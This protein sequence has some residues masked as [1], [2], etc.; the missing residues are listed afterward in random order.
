[1]KKVSL[2]SIVI[3]KLSITIIVITLV[4]NTSLALSKI[5]YL[6]FNNDNYEMYVWEGRNVVFLTPTNDLDPEIMNLYIKAVDDAYEFYLNAT[7]KRPIMHNSYNYNG[8][9]TIAIV[10]GTC[11]AGCGFLGL[12]GIEIDKNYFDTEYKDIRDKN[13]YGQILFYELGRNFWFYGNKIEMGSSATAFAVFMRDMVYESLKLS[14]GD[15]RGRP[16]YELTN[17][18]EGLLA[19]YLADPRY[20][21]E[22]TILE[23]NAPQNSFNLGGESMLTSFLYYLEE[24]YGEF[25][26]INKLWKEAGNRQDAHDEYKAADNFIIASSIAANQNLVPLFQNWRWPVSQNAI[27]EIAVLFGEGQMITTI[28]IEDNYSKVTDVGSNG[29]VKIRSFPINSNDKGVAI[30]DT[31]DKIDVAFNIPSSG[32]YKLRVWL[33]SGNSTNPTSYFNP[34]Y[35]YQFDISGIGIV[36]FDGVPTSVQGPYTEWGGSHWGFMEATVNFS[37]GGP[38]TLG[39]TAKYVWQAVDYLEIIEENVSS[40]CEGDITLSSQAEVDAFNCTEVL[41]NLTISG[42]DITNLEGLASLTTIRGSL[43]ISNNNSLA[44]LDGLSSVN[45]V[46][47][48]SIQSN[49]ALTNIDGLTSIT[50]AYY[51][52]ISS[53]D[54]LTNIDGLH[55]VTSAT[56]IYIF[57]NNLLEDI[58]GLSSLTTLEGPLIISNNNSLHNLDGLLSLNTIGI[59]DWQYNDSE[60]LIISGNDVLTNIDGLSSLTSIEGSLDIHENT[61]LLNLDGLS[62]LTSVGDD[63]VIQS[64]PAL[65]SCCGLFP[66]LNAVGVSGSID[67]SNNGAGCTQIDI[68]EGGYCDDQTT[69]KLE[70]EDNYS[71][72]SDVGSNGTIIIR[73]FP[74]NSNGK[75][76]AIPDMGDKI[77]VTFNIPAAGQYKLK[78][79]LRSGNATMPTSYF[80]SDYSYQ[81]DISGIGDVHFVGVPSSVQGPFDAWGGSHW[82]FMEATVNF[83]SSGTKT[84]GIMAKYVWQAVDYLEIIEE[85]VCVVCEGDITLS[86]Q[87]EVDAF[88]CTEV[89]GL[90]ISGR[91]ITNL[92]GLASLIKVFS[93]FI[94]DNANLNNIDGLHSLKTVNNILIANNNSLTNL[95]GLSSVTSLMSISIV[96]NQ[97]LKN[98]DGLSSINKPYEIGIDNNDALA[99]IDGLCSVTSAGYIDISNNN[100]LENIDGLSSLSTLYDE[101]L[102]ISGND[103]LTNIDGLSLLTSIYRNMLITDNNILK[104]LDGFSS[105]TSVGEDLVVQDNPALISCCGLFPLLNAGGVSGSIDISNNGAGC[106]QN[107]ILEGGS[108]DDQTTTKIEIEDNYS[109]VSDVGSNGAIIIRSFSINSNGKAVAIPD[110]GDKINVAFDIPSAGQYKLKVWLRSG[111]ATMPTSYFNTD[112]SYQFDISGIGDVKFV[113]VPSSVQGPFDE[114]GGS[115]WG[116]MEATIDFSSGG[117]KTLGIMAKYVW[118]A[119]DYLEIMEENGC[120]ICEGD[121]TLSS[122]AEVDAF[123]CTEVH[124]NLTIC[125][126]DI[127]NLDGLASLIIIEKSL[128]ISNNNSLLNLDGLS[129]LKIIAFDSYWAYPEGLF[130]SGNDVLTNLDGLSSLVNSVI[131]IPIDITNNQALTNIDGLS[132]ITKT[133]NIYIEN[134]K[135]L[136]NI[137][138][139]S[140]ITSVGNIHIR[141]NNLLENINGLS[142]LN[143]IPFIAI[144]N[145]NSLPNLDG[146]SSLKAIGCIAERYPSGCFDALIIRDNDV[147]TNING[148][149]SLTNIGCG[150]LISGNDNLVTLDGLSSLTSVGMDLVVQDNPALVRCCGLFPL[151][152]AGGVDGIID[153]SNNGAGCTEVDILEG[154]LVRIRRQQKLKSR[155]IIAKCRM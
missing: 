153:I 74:I 90:Y 152:N 67:I 115:H 136:T 10:E 68:I 49:Q 21:W 76:V 8:K 22:N 112:Y 93:L 146:L 61:G 59:A 155:I 50:S 150:I 15:F 100:L 27:D 78:V 70:I 105:L 137:D 104:N 79:W 133:G 87:A 135:A 17:E 72:L 36:N 53:N 138:G 81:F 131:P 43:T 148:L 89:G 132:S 84:L 142:S 58:T 119:V 32:Q 2:F 127:T 42:S 109:K 73:S 4:A 66:L 55:S 107:D 125:G 145:N 25:D 11:G 96:D 46:M 41:G 151:L 111:N 29:A 56:S 40:V 69:T 110:M 37:S 94:R 99:N 47:S 141:N 30:P 71:V 121:I 28:E 65:I 123:N 98:I 122:Q 7:G 139:L 91:D 33:R 128:I 38:K 12:T 147:L 149:S 31:G 54:V 60:G 51:I 80:N 144:S 19:K 39:I 88:N 120:L 103:V 63:L 48:I 126:S 95:D 106:T 75:A 6:S 34:D 62:S 9:T 85:N 44:N 101:G 114:W 23:G 102:S 134:N 117:A 130:I 24:K 140:S 1:M 116:F 113:G 118:Q 13:L 143:E 83:A 86:S 16:F 52:S 57:G 77:N 154:G 26:F 129:S 92:D 20:N 124:G 14:P 3:R 35:S 18:V 5:Q 45:S 82:G 97:A 108:C 64:N